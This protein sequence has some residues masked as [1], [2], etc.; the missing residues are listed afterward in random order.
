MTDDTSAAV[1]R[2]Q[3]VT[4]HGSEWYEFRRDYLIA[5]RSHIAALDAALARQMEGRDAE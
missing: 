3:R 1:E 4:P 5:L 2:L